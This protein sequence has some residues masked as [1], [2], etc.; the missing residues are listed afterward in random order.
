MRKV[1]LGA[2]VRPAADGGGAEALG[3]SPAPTHVPVRIWPSSSGV[4]RTGLA[5]HDIVQGA[6]AFHLWGLLGWHDIRR[7]YRRSKL[8]PFW[9]TITMGVLV[10]ALGT[11]YGALFKLDVTVYVP[12][13]ALGL[14]V[15]GLLSG[16]V[17]EGC[18]A[19]VN[20]ESIIKQTHM[21]L[22]VHVYRLIWRNLIIFVHNAVIFVAVAI[23]FSVWPGWPGMLALPGL[24]LLCLNGMWAGLFLGIV[25]ARFRDVPPIVGSIMRVAFFVTPIIWMPELVPDRALMLNI[26]PFHHF[27]MLVRAPLLGEVPGLVSWFVVLGIT[28]G[29]WLATFVLFSGYR[30]RIAYWV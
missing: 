27:L 29:G 19:F 1:Q 16:L 12:H 17:T 5:L 10:G 21:P 30:W 25:S 28:F 26:N 15:W 13:L 20:A 7:R 23:V 8:G 14:I 4:S 18:T 2:E 9:L 3:R 22:S 6:C 11:L 24:V